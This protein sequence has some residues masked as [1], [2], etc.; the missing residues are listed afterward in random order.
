M[1]MALSYLR[2]SQKY[3]L[4]LLHLSSSFCPDISRSPILTTQ[5]AL[6][7]LLLPPLAL[8]LPNFDSLSSLNAD[9]ARFLLV[10]ATD[11][12]TRRDLSVS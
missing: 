12:A 1:E 5:S 2:T 4:D 9:L 6:H 10:Y 11:V 7:F 8:S 3:S